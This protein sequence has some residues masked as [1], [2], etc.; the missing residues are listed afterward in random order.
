MLPYL[1]SE[2]DVQEVVGYWP[3]KWHEPMTL[4]VGTRKVIEISTAQK[5]KDAS[6]KAVCTLAKKNKKEVAK[7]T[8]KKEQ[9]E[10]ECAAKE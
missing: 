9:M 10:K 3:E 7:A 4:N 5:R 6:Q 8:A 1:V 2:I